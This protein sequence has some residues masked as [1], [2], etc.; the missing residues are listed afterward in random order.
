MEKSEIKLGARYAV[1][2][3]GMYRNDPT[4]VVPASVIRPFSKGTWVVVRDEDTDPDKYRSI[5]DRTVNGVQSVNILAPWTT[6]CVS[7][8]HVEAIRED[9]LRDRQAEYEA[10]WTEREREWTPL[11]EALLGIEV[12]VEGEDR[13]LGKWL[14]DRFLGDRTSGVLVGF[15]VFAAVAR[16]LIEAREAAMNAGGG[17][18]PGPTDT[19][20]ATPDGPSMAG[21]QRFARGD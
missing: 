15:D 17:W 19:G 7:E 3:Q 5:K 13:D 18:G 4:E 2:L 20:I 16:A 11:C 9:A 8:A 21:L 1:R 10:K 12:Y 14:H 6:Y